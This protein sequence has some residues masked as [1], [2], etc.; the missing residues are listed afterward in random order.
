[1]VGVETEVDMIE[2]GVGVVDQYGRNNFLH[3]RH[4]TA[5]THDDGART[6]NLLA[7]RILLAH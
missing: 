7:V 6:D 3:V 5:G 1:M 4:L 2:G